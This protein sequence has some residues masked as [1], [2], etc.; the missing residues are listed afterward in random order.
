MFPSSHCLRS[1]GSKQ[2]NSKILVLQVLCLWKHIRGLLCLL[3]QIA[4][5]V[6]LHM[7]NV[8]FQPILELAQM[9][10]EQLCTVVEIKHCWSAGGRNLCRNSRMMHVR[11]Q[12][13]W[14]KFLT[15]DKAP[16]WKLSFN[17]IY[18]L[19]FLSSVDLTS[20]HKI[21]PRKKACTYSF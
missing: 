4:C 10:N 21:S 18:Y 8:I 5:I 1:Y 7:R 20:I 16:S 2:K 12:L 17:F 15:P 11:P 19:L 13:K 9:D 3:V 14:T 6:H